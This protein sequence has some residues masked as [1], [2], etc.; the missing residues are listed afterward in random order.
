MAVYL[1]VR[2]MIFLVIKKIYL[3]KG[4]KNDCERIFWAFNFKNCFC[5][6]PFI[7]VF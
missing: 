4:N 2:V 7:L 6:C 3:I 1:P 5:I